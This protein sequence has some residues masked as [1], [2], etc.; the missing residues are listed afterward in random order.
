MSDTPRT[1]TMRDKLTTLLAGE[2]PHH[3]ANEPPA[4]WHSIAVGCLLDGLKEPSDPVK[5][6]G[7]D[8]VGG[9]CEK[10]AVRFDVDEA[11]SA[12]QAMIQHIRDGGK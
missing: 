12:W 7:G 11:M 9:Y 1:D 6:A 8:A 3:P 4:P 5:W 10:A 2:D